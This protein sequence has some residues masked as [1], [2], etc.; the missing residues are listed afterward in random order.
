MNIHSLAR[1][2]FTIGYVQKTTVDIGKS[3]AVLDQHNCPVIENKLKE[4]MHKQV[5]SPREDCALDVSIGQLL[6]NDNHVYPHMDAAVKTSIV[7]SIGHEL[8]N[9]VDKELN[10]KSQEDINPTNI[11]KIMKK[12][13]SGSSKNNTYVEQAYEEHGS[14]IGDSNYLLKQIISIPDQKVQKEAMRDFLKFQ[15]RNIGHSFSVGGEIEIYK[16]KESLFSKIKI[17]FTKAKRLELE[18][19]WQTKTHLKLSQSVSSF[20]ASQTTLK[21]HANEEK[22]VKMQDE[23]LSAINKSVYSDEKKLNKVD[24][25][26]RIRAGELVIIPTGWLGHATEIIIKGNKIAYANRGQRLDNA[27]RSGISI[28]TMGENAD[29]SKFL[30]QLLIGEDGKNSILNIIPFFKNKEKE[31]QKNF[32]EGD[33]PNSLRNLLDV[34]DLIFLQ[35]KGQKVGNCAWISAKCAFEASM[36]LLKLSPEYNENKT[37][38]AIK[39]ECNEIYKAWN[40]EHKS[41]ELESTLSLIKVINEG[42]EFLS[43]KD[44]FHL[45][46]QILAKISSND[47][48]IDAQALRNKIINNLPNLPADDCIVR[49]NNLDDQTGKDLARRIVS[50]Q[51]GEIITLKDTDFKN[52]DGKLVYPDM[53]YPKDYK[54]AFTHYE[55]GDVVYKSNGVDQRNRAGAYM[56]IETKGGVSLHVNRLSRGR[57]PELVTYRLQKQDDKTYLLEIPGKPTEIIK[58]SKDLEMAV[59]KHIVPQDSFGN[60]KP[61]PVHNEVLINDVINK[62]VTRK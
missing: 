31:R 27:G 33:R 39:Q 44:E 32:L 1:G 53:A 52:L 50:K 46:A 30:D 42:S 12:L 3:D 18:G 28:Y 56:L 15:L 5:E 14:K 24:L 8:E 6:L 9:L 37:H 59:A 62:N 57:T 13:A 2:Q 55:V 11:A 23:I 20:F 19:D 7:S 35:K 26:R 10:G 22:N 4:V 40:V 21:L 29:I 43:K 45:Y 41:N 61:Y 48:S 38:A 58:N 51:L 36:Y 34:K 60:P 54:K 49:M 16:S 25:E 17:F 47:P